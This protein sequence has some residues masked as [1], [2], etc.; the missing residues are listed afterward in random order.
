VLRDDVFGPSDG[1]VTLGNPELSVV[2]SVSELACAPP[3]LCA[4]PVRGSGV[5]DGSVDDDVPV[6]VDDVDEVV[7]DDDEVTPDGEVDTDELEVLSVVDDEVLDV[8]LESV[9]S[10]RA[11]PGIVA[12]ADPTPR[13]TAKAP[14]RP[15]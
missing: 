6:A 15:T 7:V 11:T 8:P 4:T 13:A 3:V 2:L 1:N 9:G 5:I 10:A 14:T 12:T